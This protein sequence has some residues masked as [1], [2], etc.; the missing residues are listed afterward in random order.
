LRPQPTRFPALEYADPLRKPLEGA[1]RICREPL[2]RPC[3][4]AHLGLH[5]TD[6]ELRD[7]R[8]P[9]PAIA[10]QL[11]PPG[12]RTDIGVGGVAHQE[13]MQVLE[14]FGAQP[15]QRPVNVY[16]RA[17]QVLLALIRARDSL[18]KHGTIIA[19]STDSIRTRFRF[20]ALSPYFQGSARDGLRGESRMP[21]CW[22]GFVD[23]ADQRLFVDALTAVDE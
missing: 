15:R 16:H 11:L 3:R 6:R 9:G 10:N 22:V 20:A 4:Q 12:Q 8:R 23:D 7:Q 19:S 1:H 13:V 2:R 5:L 14:L 18:L 17:Q 21:L